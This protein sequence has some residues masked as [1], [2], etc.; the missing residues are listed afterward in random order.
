MPQCVCVSWLEKVP[1]KSNASAGGRMYQYWQSGCVSLFPVRLSRLWLL[2]RLQRERK[3]H[4]PALR[5]SERPFFLRCSGLSWYLDVQERNSSDN[6]RKGVWSVRVLRHHTV[7]CH[8]IYLC[9]RMFVIAFSANRINI[10][11]DPLASGLESMYRAKRIGCLRFKVQH[12]GVP[13]FQGE[14]GR[15]S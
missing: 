13:D 3:T 9:M 1:F 7:P 14:R 15:R 6:S 10:V 12:C 11:T 4:P 8:H 5:T 2:R